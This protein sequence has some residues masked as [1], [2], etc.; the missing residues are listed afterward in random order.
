VA[1][2][3]L[4]FLH[5]L[6]SLWLVAG[7]TAVMLP[8]VRAWSVEEL[9]LQVLAIEEAH[10]YQGLLL[11]PGTVAAG[12]TGAFYWAQAGYN[13]FATGW[14]LA[15]GLLYLLV[16]LVCLPLIGIGLRRLRLAA[17]QAA[18]E[19]SPTPEL[20]EALA[21]RVPLVFGGLAF[22]ALPALVA[23]SVFGP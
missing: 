22:L 18:R 11:I 8:L 2:K 3:A 5:L 1:E 23:L 16:L 10:H 17:L 21:D 4:L 19:G 7:L 9:S 12:A 15:L 20:A 14:L 6:A 13:L